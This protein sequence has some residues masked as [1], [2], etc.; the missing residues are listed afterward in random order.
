M[1]W[2]IEPFDG[3]AIV[4]M[5]SNRANKQNPEF[6]A[7]LIEAFD[8]LDRDHPRSPIVLT[9][10]DDFFSVGIDFEYTFA[11]FQR[12]DLDAI[13]TWFKGF[14]GA[15]LRVFGTLRPTVAA[16]N[17]HAYAG[18]LI[19]ALCCDARVARRGDLHCSVNEVPVGIPMPSVY[20]ELIRHRLGTPTATEAILTGRTYTPEE[21][22]AAGIYQ[23]VVDPERL[24]PQAV[25]RARCVAP[26]C[27]PAYEHSKRMLQTPVMQVVASLSEALD[28][29]TTA[30]VIASEPC[31]RAQA[32]AL[33]LLRQRKSAQRAG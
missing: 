9:G 14:R 26:E 27:L 23:Q 30:P 24:I 16:V 4:R 20:T 32:R 6:F 25:E 18:G 1:R 33:A 21:A 3:A 28:D 12:G 7:D 8:R 31:L 10:T 13:R 15:M 22:V 11:L 29:E 19:L 2:E 17:G 5:R